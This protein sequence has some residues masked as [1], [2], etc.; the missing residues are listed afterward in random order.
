MAQ[1]EDGYDNCKPAKRADMEKHQGRRKRGRPQMR[2]ED[3]VRR[4][5]GRS[6]ED[7]RRRKEDWGRPIENYGKK[8]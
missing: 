6:W 4:D 1:R 8:E 7:E 3:C 5:M 2:W